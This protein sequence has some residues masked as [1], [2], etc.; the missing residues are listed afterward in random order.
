MARDGSGYQ[1]LHN[2]RINQVDGS[3]PG[4]GV[5]EASDGRLF[6]TTPGGGIYNKGTLFRLNKDGSDYTV[7]RSFEPDYMGDGQN[8]I[9]RLVEGADGAL[10][11]TI[12]FMVGIPVC[13]SMATSSESIR[14]ETI[15]RGF[16]LELMV[17]MRVCLRLLLF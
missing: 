8:P 11:G 10:Y 14:T 5:I 4:S 6:G 3:R 2:F 12:R 7:L 16:N 13:L 1:I 9:G 15:I 17:A